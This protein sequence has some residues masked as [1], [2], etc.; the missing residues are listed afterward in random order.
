MLKPPYPKW[1]FR[2]N[3]CSELNQSSQRYP[4]RTVVN[5]DVWGFIFSWA[6]FAFEC[7]P[8][9]IVVITILHWIKLLLGSST[10][11]SDSVTVVSVF[12]SSAPYRHKLRPRQAAAFKLKQQRIYISNSFLF[13]VWPLFSA[14][15]KQY[16]IVLLTY[17]IIFCIISTDWCS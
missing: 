10:W 7:E 16:F 9:F 6:T 2:N 13:H 5:I 4:F 15:S 1:D 8:F 11:L 14:D 12:V 17:V 3:Y